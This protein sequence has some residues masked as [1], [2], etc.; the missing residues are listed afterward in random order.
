MK[1]IEVPDSEEII[2]TIYNIAPEVFINRGSSN[3]YSPKCDM[4]ATGLI[5]YQLIAGVNPVIKLTPKKEINNQKTKMMIVKGKI[6]FK[7]ECWE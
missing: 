1:N 6:E 2:G 7:D 3:S 4:W 5:C